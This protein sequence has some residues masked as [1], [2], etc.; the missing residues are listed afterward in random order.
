M[1]SKAVSVVYLVMG[2]DKGA[3]ELSVIY[4]V[5]ETA[6]CGRSATRKLSCVHD[7]VLGGSAGQS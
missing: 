2:G 6:L 5:M 1:P 7:G 3:R 4:D